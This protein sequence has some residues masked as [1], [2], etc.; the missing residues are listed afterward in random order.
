MEDKEE[1]AVAE[2]EADSSAVATAEVV[3]TWARWW[4]WMR[5]MAADRVRR[6][7]HLD[8]TRAQTHVE[9]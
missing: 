4:W 2:A 1:A 3:R 9:A 7:A 8:R 5:T 6:Y